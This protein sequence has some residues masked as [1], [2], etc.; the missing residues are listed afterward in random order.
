MVVGREPAKW[1]ERGDHG[2][3]EFWE[4][5]PRKCGEEDYVEYLWRK[6]QVSV[7]LAT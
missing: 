7:G 2:E 1:C 5:L 4:E 3:E 6:R